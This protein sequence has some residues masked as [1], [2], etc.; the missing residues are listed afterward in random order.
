MNVFGSKTLKNV[1]C[2]ENSKKIYKM[3]HFNKILMMLG[4]NC[5]LKMSRLKCDETL[6]FTLYIPYNLVLSEVA[7][8]LRSLF[9]QFIVS[10][11]QI[12]PITC[13]TFDLS[14]LVLDAH[15][16]QLASYWVIPKERP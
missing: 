9:I 11:D 15:N 3:R 1:Y 14:L 5:P 4:Q 10:L 6:Q 7:V 12:F 16:V 2:I 8:I 13:S